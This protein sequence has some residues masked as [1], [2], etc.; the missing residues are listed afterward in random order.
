MLLR[1]YADTPENFQAW[2]HQHSNSWRRRLSGMP[3]HRAVN[4]L[5]HKRASTAM[6]L[7][8][9]SPSAASGPDLTHL[10]SRDTLASGAMPNNP[11]NLAALV[12]QSRHVQAR[13]R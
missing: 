4:N 6:R 12:R 10:M 3:R 2:I 8:A 13:A 11:E 9:P 7:R 5:K 1:V